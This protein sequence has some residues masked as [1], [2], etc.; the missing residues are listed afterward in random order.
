MLRVARPPV[1]VLSAADIAR[2]DAAW[3]TIISEIGVQFEHAGALALLQE[4]GQR[5]EGETV[6]FDADWVASLVAQTPSTFTWH[7]RNP[8]RSLGAGRG[9]CERG[10]Q[11][12]GP[13]ARP[14]DRR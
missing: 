9:F 5:V 6:F 13:H 12:G 8:A 14:P 7:A 2:I 3:R 1:D 10:P 4:A 11:G